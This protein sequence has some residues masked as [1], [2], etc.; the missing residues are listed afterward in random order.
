MSFLNILKSKSEKEEKIAAEDLKKSL[1]NILIFIDSIKGDFDLKNIYD[2][3]GQELAKKKISTLFTVYDNHRNLIALKNYYLH[4]E[5]LKILRKPDKDNIIE[6][7]ISLSE[8][9][10]YQKAFK[11]KKAQFSRSGL[12]IIKMDDDKN[13]INKNLKLNS[14]VA[15]LVFKHEI[16]GALELCSQHI[17]RIHTPAVDD[18]AKDFSFFVASS[19]LF[20]EIKFSEARYRGLFENA[21]EGFAI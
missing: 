14:I 11:E 19:I 2:A 17:D 16:I 15:P 5:V 20:H 1:D 7:K 3:I 21:K 12:E 10:N 13:K 18:F 6:K 9:I 4:P 8:L